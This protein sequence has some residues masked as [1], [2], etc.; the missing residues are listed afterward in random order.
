M[1]RGASEL[2]AAIEA[3]LG[4]LPA[5]DGPSDRRWGV[6]HTFLVE[7]DGEDQS[8]ARWIVD[9]AHQAG[10]APAPAELVGRMMLRAVAEDLREIERSWSTPWRG[11]RARCAT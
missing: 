8:H 7:L 1:L 3:H 6:R 10:D 5:A 11:R 2:V 4:K 9:L